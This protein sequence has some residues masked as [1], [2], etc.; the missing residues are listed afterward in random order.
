MQSAYPRW[1]SDYVGHSVC[2]T[3]NP[4]QVLEPVPV[5]RCTAVAAT[6]SSATVTHGVSE[7]TLGRLAG[8]VYLALEKY[9]SKVKPLRGRKPTTDSA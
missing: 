2:L 4:V 5:D 6:S 7:S 8:L 9:K 3:R 1:E